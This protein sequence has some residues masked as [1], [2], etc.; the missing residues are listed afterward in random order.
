M[1]LTKLVRRQHN[2]SRRS[3]RGISTIMANLTMLV[4]VVSLSSMLFIW[5]TSSLGSYAGGAGYWY[6]SRSIA[7]QEKPSVE[8]V[9][10][11]KAPN[12]PGSNSYC[13]TVYVRNVGTVP[14]TI[15]SIYLNSTLY[16]QSY[17][18]VLV[19]QVQQFQ[20][21]LVGQSWVQGDLQT[22]T[23]ATLR[24]TVVQTTWVP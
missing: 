2:R 10:F 11:G 14:F 5:A 15:S 6:S 19:S 7:N 21:P 24:G 4:I 22:S 12:C 3:R 8:N 16:T 18:P 17:P 23:V 13:V 9:F 1:T 20:F